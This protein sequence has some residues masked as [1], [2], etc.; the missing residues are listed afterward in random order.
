MVLAIGS[1]VMTFFLGQAEATLPTG[2]SLVSPLPYP[3]FPEPDYWF[4]REL[5]EGG[6]V[7]MIKTSDP[8]PGRPVELWKPGVGLIPVESVTPGYEVSVV[9]SAVD[10]PLCQPGIVYVCG[11]LTSIADP[12]E[13]LGFVYAVDTMSGSISSVITGGIYITRYQPNDGSYFRMNWYD[14]DATPISDYELVG[15]PPLPL[16]PDWHV[17]QGMGSKAGWA[18]QARNHVTGVRSVWVYLHETGHWQE[19]PIPNGDLVIDISNSGLVVMRELIA[20]GDVEYHSL[21]PDGTVQSYAQI[22]DQIEASNSYGLVLSREQ[23]FDHSTGVATS[24]TDRLTMFD[25]NDSGLVVG[26][27]GYYQLD[28]ITTIPVGGCGNWEDLGGSSAGAMGEPRLAADGSQLAG[29][30][31]SVELSNAPPNTLTLAWLSSA[32]TP[33]A[34][35]GG[36]LFAFP[37]DLQILMASDALGDV[38]GTAT[39]PSG[40]ASGTEFFLQFLVQD[41]SVTDQ[42]T[43]SNAVRSTAP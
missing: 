32:S 38:G 17:I 23:V 20:P 31:L 7:L 42:V 21:G 14:P 12:D 30:I 25:M 33:V 40:I 8:I 15:F 19:A 11:R 28:P 16:A 13:L 36:T 5:T 10:D 35:F 43:L 2:I 37:Y 9:N 34:A 39:W 24:F 6:W 41:D 4:P 22:T 26:T 3:T 27:G 18:C 1:V 29:S